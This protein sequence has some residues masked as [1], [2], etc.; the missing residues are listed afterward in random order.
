MGSDKEK[1]GTSLYER[2]KGKRVGFSGGK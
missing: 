1:K 2:E